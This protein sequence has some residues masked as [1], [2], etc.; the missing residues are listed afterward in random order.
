[1]KWIDYDMLVIQ[2][3]SE[4]YKSKIKDTRVV[5][6]ASEAEKMLEEA[7]QADELKF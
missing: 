3:V 5:C 4:N 2:R 1:M 7:Q 6:T